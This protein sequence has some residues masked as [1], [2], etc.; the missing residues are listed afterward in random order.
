M[1]HK[2]SRE[3]KVKSHAT[4]I[5][6]PTPDELPQGAEGFL[7]ACVRAAWTVDGRRVG[8]K[9]PGSRHHEDYTNY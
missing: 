7:S 1:T 8:I 2:V 6:L 5:S 9:P 3:L 4:V